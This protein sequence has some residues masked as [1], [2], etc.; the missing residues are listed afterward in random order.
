MFIMSL[1]EENNQ[2]IDPNG[3]GDPMMMMMGVNRQ[4]MANPM[5]GRITGS[6]WSIIRR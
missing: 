1:F 2:N 5:M 4:Q 3:A 6:S